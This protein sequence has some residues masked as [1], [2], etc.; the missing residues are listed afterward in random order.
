MEPSHAS[1]VF[2]GYVWLA[3]SFLIPGPN[4]Q[5]HHLEQDIQLVVSD[6]KACNNIFVKDQNVFEETEAFLTCVLSFPGNP[7]TVPYP[8]R[9]N[10]QAFGPSLL[11][12]TG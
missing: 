7:S 3:N 8:S 9:S 2:W 10:M 11:S 12:T 1:M 6:P 4:N 5:C